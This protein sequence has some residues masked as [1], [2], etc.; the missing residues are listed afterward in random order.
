MSRPANADD[1]DDDDSRRRQSTTT[2][3]R[4]P[5]DDDQSDD[6]QSTTT[7]DDQSDE[8]R[9]VRRPR[10]LRQPRP[11]ARGL[12]LPPPGG[13]GSVGGG[14][15]GGG[16]I[17]V[18]PGIPRTAAG[19]AAPACRANHLC[20]T[21]SRASAPRP[22]NCRCRRSLCR[23]SS[24]LRASGSEAAVGP[25][26]RGRRRCRRHRAASQPSRPRVANRCRPTWAA[27]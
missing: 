4:R 25:R 22:R 26:R 12:G 8:Q 10:P 24:R 1:D 17:E 23:L 18:P 5:V 20:S 6:D 9:P 2:V 16:A 14:G 21:P 13:S 19:G 15:G 27:T 7:A 3:R 11:T